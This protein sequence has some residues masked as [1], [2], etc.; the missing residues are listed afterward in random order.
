LFWALLIFVLSSIPSLKTPDLGFH[1][2]DKLAHAAEYGILGWLVFRS[3]RLF[4]TG[5]KRT[6]FLVLLAGTAYAAVDEF[7]QLFVPGRHADLLDFVAD[8]LGVSASQVTLWLIRS[9]KK[10]KFFS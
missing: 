2:Q 3:F 8:A 5:L 7:H 9:G 4:T 10:I 1:A 6:V